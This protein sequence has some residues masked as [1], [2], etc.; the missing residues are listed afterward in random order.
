M[1][2]E[3]KSLLRSFYFPLLFVVLMWL[4]KGIELYFETSFSKWGVL[5]RTLEG[6]RGILF[7]PLIHGDL[8]HLFN[9]SIPMLVLGTAVFYF[10]KPIAYRLFFLIFFIANI[11]LW[12]LG[13]QNFHIGASGIVY[14]LAAFLFFSGILRR[15]IPLL[16]ISLLVA[17]LYGSLVWGVF[18]GR[19]RVSFEGHLTGTFAGIVLA[20]YFRK[21]GPQRKKY[22]WEDEPEDEIDDDENAYWK[23]PEE[24]PSVPP[25]GEKHS[26]NE[27]EE[28]EI[29]YTYHYKPGPKNHGTNS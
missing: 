19:E 1:Q 21:E 29:N 7:S 3:K 17:F 6:L 10:Y 2:P 18:P 28:K 24:K 27:E 15:H 11:W 13:R 25:A 23:I 14:G 26:A 12:A 5:P 9:N 20:F 22:R 4:V 16:V 8:E